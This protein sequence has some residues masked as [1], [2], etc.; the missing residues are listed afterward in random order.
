MGSPLRAVIRLAIYLGWTM[1][2]IPVQAFALGCHRPLSKRL[3]LL[4]HSWCCRILGLDV[5][6]YGDMSEVRSTLFVSNHTS[7]VDIMVLAS[8]VPASFVAKAEVARWPFFGFLARLQRTIFVDRR[9]GSATAHRDEILKRLRNGES[10]FLF[11]EGTSD[12]GNRVLP[13][14]STLFSVAQFEIDNRPIVVQPVSIAYTHLDGMPIGRTLKP[15][16]AWY[17][18][19]G[20]LSHI[21]TLFGLGVATV[22]VT[23]H[24]PAHYIEHG[25]RKALAE[26]CFGV[27]ARG[28]AEANA[29]VGEPRAAG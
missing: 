8:I 5:Q 9:I 17:G 3:P 12:D 14:K 19:M 23:F 10:L 6:V 1:L 26:H 22:Q 2:L 11:P 28:V 16:F 27:V 25:S 20:L 15:Y 7:Y 29:G 4:Y 13:F 21:W 18:D 24:A